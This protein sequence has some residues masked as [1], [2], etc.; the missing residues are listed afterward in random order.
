MEQADNSEPTNKARIARL[1]ISQTRIWLIHWV[2]R[3]FHRF[4]C[5]LVFYA[6]F[7]S[8]RTSFRNRAALQLEIVALRHQLSVLQRS[9]KR[10]RLKATDRLL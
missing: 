2:L 5:G 3:T 10:P 7:A 9:V 1:W 6:L 4:S 8:L